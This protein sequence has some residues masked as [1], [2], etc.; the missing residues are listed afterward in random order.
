M[1]VLV[2]HFKVKELPKICFEGM[3]EGGK[4]IAMQKRRQLRDADPA[5]QEKKRLARLEELKARMAEIQR[6]KEEQQDKK[7]KREEVD[8]EE[9]EVKKAV[10]QEER[11]GEMAESEE[12]VVENDETDL[13]ASALD[14]IQEAGENKTREEAEAEKE[15]LLA[16]ELLEEEADLEGYESDENAVGY[17]KDEVRQVILQKTNK[18]EKYKDMRSLPVADEVAETLRKL[19]YNIVSDDEAIILGANMIPPW[20]QRSTTEGEDSTSKDNFPRRMKI[21]FHEKFDM[22]ELDALGHVIDQGDDDF[23]PSKTWVGRKAG[24]ET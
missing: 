23:T 21:T 7:R 11:T 3:Y 12:A 10:K 17:T 24:F 22:V 14:T 2:K 4:A 5:R 18:E 20:R 9:E 16:G 1:D 8:V 15:K 6:K 13:L 19:G